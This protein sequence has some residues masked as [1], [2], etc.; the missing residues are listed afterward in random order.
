MGWQ[1][2]AAIPYNADASTTWSILRNIFPVQGTCYAVTVTRAAV[3]G[4]FK[5]TLRFDCLTAT[6]PYPNV[7]GACPP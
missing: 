3:A 6:P 4:G 5:W 7:V 1:T 2:T